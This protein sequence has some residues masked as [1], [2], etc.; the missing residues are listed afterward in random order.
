VVTFQNA[1]KVTVNIEAGT[2]AIQPW[3]LTMSM[4]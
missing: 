1:R 2:R 4:I 3:G